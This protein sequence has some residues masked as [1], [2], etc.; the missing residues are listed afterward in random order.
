MLYI[1]NPFVQKKEVDE[2]CFGSCG[3]VLCGGV[4][5]GPDL[6]GGFPCREDECPHEEKRSEIIGQ[7]FEED[8][9]LRKL[10]DT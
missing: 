1:V 2:L 5:L 10:K 7:V 9:C 3:R 6:G 8:C 4:D